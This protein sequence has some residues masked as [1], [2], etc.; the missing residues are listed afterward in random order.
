MRRYV[1]VGLVIG[2]LYGVVTGWPGGGARELAWWEFGGYLAGCI[3]GGALGG[4][5]LWVVR[6]KIERKPPR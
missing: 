5:V 4:A 2:V 3:F 1:L 6:S